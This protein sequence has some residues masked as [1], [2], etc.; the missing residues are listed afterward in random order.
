MSAAATVVVN[1][2]DIFCFDEL[3][4]PHLTR[5]AVLSDKLDLFSAASQARRQ[6]LEYCC[7]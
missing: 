2:F 4:A 7:G 5:A 3:Y 6:R 1:S